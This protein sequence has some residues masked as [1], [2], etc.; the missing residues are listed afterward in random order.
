MFDADTYAA[1][2]SRLV[3]ALDAGGLCLFLGNTESP[4]NAAANPYPF[5][6]DS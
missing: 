6:Q 2:R 3:D 1:R 4:R 5:R